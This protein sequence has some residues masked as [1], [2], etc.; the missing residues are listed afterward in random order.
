ML[1]PT[2]TR[3]DDEGY[4]PQ[5]VVSCEHFDSVISEESSGSKTLPIGGI[6]G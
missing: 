5:A 4:L 3:D 2:E 1:L 6:R